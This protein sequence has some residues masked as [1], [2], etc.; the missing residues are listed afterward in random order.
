VAAAEDHRIAMAFATLGTL[1]AAPVTVEGAATI[2]TSYPDFARDLAALGG[3][4]ERGARGA[5]REGA[6]A[7]PARAPAGTPAPPR[8]RERTR[9]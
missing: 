8:V 6:R 4:P 3:A 5:T 7:K 1:A 9:P 2:A